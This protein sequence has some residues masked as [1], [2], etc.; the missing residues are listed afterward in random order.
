[1]GCNPRARR[2]PARLRESLMIGET[3]FAPIGLQTTAAPTTRSEHWSGSARRSARHSRQRTPL[4]GVLRSDFS[5][6][7]R[8]NHDVIARYLQVLKRL[9]G[10]DF[11]AVVRIDID[12]VDK[13]DAGVDGPANEPARSPVSNCRSG[14]KFR[15]RR[16]T[17]WCPGNG[18]R[19]INRYGQIFGSAPH[20]LLKKLC[21]T[22]R[23]ISRVGDARAFRDCRHRAWGTVGAA[24]LVGPKVHLLISAFQLDEVV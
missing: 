19:R 22:T 23:E 7:F 21:L 3:A 18:L 10:D 20:R 4:P 1:M 14:P 8:G 5:L 6:C 13:V 24:P 2:A 16:R 11:R 15:R 12:R 17:S 9:T